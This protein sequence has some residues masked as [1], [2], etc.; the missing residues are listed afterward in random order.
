VRVEAFGGG[1]EE[2]RLARESKRLPRPAGWPRTVDEV[3]APRGD[4]AIF[5]RWRVDSKYDQEG[6]NVPFAKHISDAASPPAPADEIIANSR[7]EAFLAFRLYTTLLA[8]PNAMMSLSQAIAARRLGFAFAT[9]LAL[10]LSLIGGTWLFSRRTYR[11]GVVVMVVLSSLLLVAALRAVGATFGVAALLVWVCVATTTFFGRRAGVLTWSGCF[12]LLGVHA[13]TAPEYADSLAAPGA[14]FVARPIFVRYAAALLAIAAVIAATVSALTRGLEAATRELSSALARER[15]ER[16][17]RVTSERALSEA[18]RLEAI[19]RLAGGIAHDFNNMLTPIRAYADLL[20]SGDVDRDQVAPVAEVIFD[21]AG[22]AAELTRRLLQC[23]RATPEERGPLSLHRLVG[24]VMALLSRTVDRSITLRTELAAPNDVVRGDAA[25]LSSAI[26]NLAL[27][28]RDAMPQG[29]E[30]LFRTRNLDRPP[31]LEVPLSRAEAGW[32]ELQVSDTGVGIEPEIA[33]RVFEPF[34]TTKRPGEGTGLGLAAVLGTVQGHDGAISV[35]SRPGAGTRFR[36]LLPTLAGAAVAPTLAPPRTALR[37]GG[38]VLIVE[39][40]LAVRRVL[41]RIFESLGFSCVE[42]PDGEAGLAAFRACKEL[43]RLV[44]L[45]MIMPGRTGAEVLA[46][47]R[48]TQKALPVLIVTGFAPASEL[49]QVLADPRVVQLHKPFR[50]AELV[51]AV[52][53]LL[54]RPA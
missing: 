7:F 9:V 50:R 8:I 49:A 18:R 29:G 37:A 6:K 13:L 3:R 33:A 35:E 2:P 19:G 12:L 47:I 27:N 40:E 31:E 48:E 25:L 39:D 21:A 15:A 4:G 16:E 17:A 23:A 53:A 24:D 5:R 32:L 14:V 38:H 51:A 1:H 41:V 52:E 36:V 43:P 26:L 28:A 34:F 22:R 45:D 11:R 30:L 10:Q 20:R 46:V 54:A 42:A 44:V